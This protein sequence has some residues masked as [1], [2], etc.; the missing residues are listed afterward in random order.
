MDG[1]WAV[2]IEYTKADGGYRAS[3]LHLGQGMVLTADHCCGG[4]TYRVWSRE[5]TGYLTAYEATVCWRSGDTSGADLALLEVRDL[6]HTPRHLSV[7]FLDRS[8]PTSL[9]GCIALCFPKYKNDAASQLEGSIPL[10]ENSAGRPPEHVAGQRGDRDGIPEATLRLTHEGPHIAAGLTSAQAWAGASGAGIVVTRWGQHYCVGVVSNHEPPEHAKH[11]R[12]ATFGAL[13]TLTPERQI[14]FWTKLGV[15]SP[16]VVTLDAEGVHHHGQVV[17]GDRPSAAANFVDRAEADR[18]AKATEQSGAVTICALRGMRGVG[19]TQLAAAL[20]R[21]RQAAGW[22]VIAWIDAAN[23]STIESDLIRLA[24]ALNHRRSDEEPIDSIHRMFDAFASDR[25]VPRLLVYDNVTKLDDLSGLVP[26][27]AAAH[28]VIT[29]TSQGSYGTAIDV[30]VFSEDQAIDYLVATTGLDD[31][32]GARRVAQYLGLLPL[33]LDQASATIRRLHLTFL[34]YLEALKTRALDEVLLREP[35]APYPDP[36]G[37]A[38]LFAIETTLSTS[39]TADLAEAITDALSLL[40]ASGVPA[41]WFDALGDSFQVARAI[42]HLEENSLVTRSEIGGLL[43]MHRLVRRVCRE[44]VGRLD[45]TDEARAST[46]DEHALTIICSV[47][48]SDDP[49]FIARRSACRE[50]AAQLGV[51]RDEDESRHLRE[52]EPFLRMALR[53]AFRANDLGD[54]HTAISLL[55]PALADSLRV[56]GPDHPDTLTSRNNLA[57][58]YE[59]AGRVAEAIPLHEETLT[60]RLRVLGPD[61]PNTLTSRNNLAGAYWAAGRVD[62]A[63]PLDEQTL[64]DRLRVLGPDHPDTLTSRNNLAVAYE[65][66]GRVAEAIPL[67]EETLTDSLRVLGP[68]HLVALEVGV[69]LV[70]LTDSLRVLGPDHPDTLT[71]RNDLACAYWGAGRRSE[72]AE[73]FCAAADLAER[74]FGPDHLV[75]R[76]LI[77]NRDEARRQLG[78]N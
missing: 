78:T 16:S 18:L 47:G 24:D 77:A 34:G 58:A 51:V 30:G 57:Y 33:A 13:A 23:P 29:T 68:D 41:Q 9:R 50:L 62:D 66:A 25:R 26:D 76:Q 67:H 28:V 52:S 5:L 55:E 72:A 59:T 20:S 10:S 22:P 19:K 21:H 42:A 63:I 4:D 49:E 45:V 71:S 64:T 38:L 27:A 69:E 1:S 54:P 48:L 36:V 74:L 35:G 14:D 15:E 8:Q 6:A 39:P 31:R 17:V 70:G 11:L 75:T 2:F 37:R 44:R 56:L 32:D 40:A 61:H 43:V 12:L 53:T 46:A 3:G 65:T 60:D 73:E 7:A